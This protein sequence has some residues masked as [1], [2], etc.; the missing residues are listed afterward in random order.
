MPSHV[1]PDTPKKGRSNEFHN[2]SRNNYSVLFFRI[3]KYL[4]SMW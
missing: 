3:F 4:V 2:K 1:N